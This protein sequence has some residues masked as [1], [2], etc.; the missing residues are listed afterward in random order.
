MKHHVL[1]VEDELVLLQALMRGLK[2]IRTLHIT[3][4]ASVEEAIAVLDEDPPE[5]LITDLN[6]PGRNG[7][8]LINE[9]LQRNLQIPVIVMTAFLGKYSEALNQH[10]SLTILE[11]PFPLEAL[12]NTIEEK[13]SNQIQQTSIGPFQLVDYLQ[14]SGMGRHSLRLQV[15]L[16]SG[17][18]AILEI[19]EGDIWNVYAGGYIGEK[20]LAFLIQGHVSKLGFVDLKNQPKE[21]QIQNRWEEVLLDIIRLQDENNQETL[22]EQSPFSLSGTFSA[23]SGSFDS[24]KAASGSFEE[25]HPPSG[26]QHPSPELVQTVPQGDATIEISPD[27]SSQKQDFLFEAIQALALN[28]KSKASISLQEFSSQNPEDKRL[29]YHWVQELVD[30]KDK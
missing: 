14:L 16:E 26:D 5:L 30:Q 10:P 2:S 25:W 4:C 15:E 24:L 6:L 18:Q 1:I 19:I 29:L 7:V 22:T 20:A 17:E 27:Q 3:G 12:R 9:L 23:A 8:D 28:Q 21:R 11:K 13:L